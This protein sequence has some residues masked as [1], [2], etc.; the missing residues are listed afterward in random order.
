VQELRGVPLEHGRASGSSE[1]WLETS[2]EGSWPCDGLFTATG[3][4]SS[5]PSVLLWRKNGVVRAYSLPWDLEPELEALNASGVQSAVATV[6]SGTP[7]GAVIAGHYL[8]SK[9]LGTLQVVAEKCLKSHDADT[10]VRGVLALRLAWNPVTERLLSS[11]D[12]ALSQRRRLL[13]AYIGK[14][15]IWDR[16]D[17]VVANAC[18]LLESL[19]TVVTENLHRLEV[20]AESP[21]SYVSMAARRAIAVGE[22]GFGGD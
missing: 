13:A 7:R 12:R 6:E 2:S 8:A 19:P 15:G 9:D 16:E 4:G 22:S 11:S 21:V 18:L 20:L 17:L 3:G 1:P 14:R 5:R 10:R